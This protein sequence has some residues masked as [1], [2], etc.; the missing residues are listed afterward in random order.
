MATLMIAPTM[1]KLFF[2]IVLDVLESEAIVWGLLYCE[3]GHS[4]DE[5]DQENIKI[6]FKK[7]RNVP[8]KLFSLKVFSSLNLVL[9]NI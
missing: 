8:I 5:I 4:F 7:W 2:W 3:C 6:A 9:L 1:A